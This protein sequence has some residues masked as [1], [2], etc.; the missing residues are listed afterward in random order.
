MPHI[1]PYNSIVPDIDKT[2]YIAETAV[3]TGDVK[4]GAETSIWYGCIMRGD[5]NAIR[6][7]KGVNIQDGSVIHVARPFACIIEDR[8]SI[9]HMALIHACTLEEGC[10]VGMKACIMDGVVVEKGAFVAAGSL[11]TPGKRVPSGELW[12]GHPARFVRKLT[13]KD[14]AIMDYTQPNYV[15]LGQAYKLEESS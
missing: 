2:A 4:I 14:Q 7:G 1:L 11:V 9:G 15:K 5:I 12:A 10:F 8:V 3:I 6:I 13:E